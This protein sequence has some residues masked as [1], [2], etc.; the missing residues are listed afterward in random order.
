MTV[1]RS[2]KAGRETGDWDVPVL[3]QTARKDSRSSQ[4]PGG[5]GGLVAGAVSSPVLP[6]GPPGGFRGLLRVQGQGGDT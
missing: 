1:I 2:S 3:S 4:E 6:Q 5:G